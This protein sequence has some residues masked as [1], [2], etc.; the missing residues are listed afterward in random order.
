MQ[1]PG[2]EMFRKQGQVVQRPWGI[3]ILGVFEE[4]QGG[5][6]TWSKVRCRENPNSLG[7]GG[8]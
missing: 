7:Q 2:G 3:S 1:L 5:G 8:H 4:Q 6:C